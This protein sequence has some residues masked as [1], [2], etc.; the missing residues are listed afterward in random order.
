MKKN[1]IKT[2][3]AAAKRFKITGTGKVV[4]KRAGTNHFG[5]RKRGNRKRALRTPN[6]LGT[7]DAGR[8]R[9][10]LGKIK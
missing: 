6:V 8:I 9:E 2:K 7:P 1:K 3:R 10:A 5:R 4:H